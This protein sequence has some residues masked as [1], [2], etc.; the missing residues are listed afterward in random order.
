MPIKTVVV[1]C[2]LCIVSDIR[3]WKMFVSCYTSMVT[4]QLTAVGRH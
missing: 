3:H 4:G 1:L 2:V